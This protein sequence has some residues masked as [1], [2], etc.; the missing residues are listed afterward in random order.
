MNIPFADGRSTDLPTRWNDF[1]S[2][3]S[4]EKLYRFASQD[5]AIDGMAGKL[6]DCVV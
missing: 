2:L 6:R 5:A 1:R 4:F 3:V